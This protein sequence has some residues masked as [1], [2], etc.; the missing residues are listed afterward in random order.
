MQ[1]GKR[2]DT[3]T[4]ETTNRQQMFG[5]TEH[6]RIPHEA[7]GLQHFDDDGNSRCRVGRDREPER[8]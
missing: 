6:F 5:G 4:G 3:A 1:K 2:K 8:K 7:I